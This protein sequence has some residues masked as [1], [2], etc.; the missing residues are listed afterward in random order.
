MSG[1]VSLSI[2]ELF[3]D[4]VD[5]INRHGVVRKQASKQVSFEVYWMLRGFVA[6]VDEQDAIDLAVALG[7]QGCANDKP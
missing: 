4:S 5:A 6:P 7:I 1:F 3:F 2:E